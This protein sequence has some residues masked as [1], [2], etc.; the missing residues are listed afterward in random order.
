MTIHLTGLSGSEFA[1]LRQWIR[2][3][4]VIDL[5]HSPPVPPELAQIDRW[6]AFFNRPG[7]KNRLVTRYLYEHL[8]LAHLYFDGLDTGNYL[9]LVRSTTP[10]GETGP[11]HSHAASE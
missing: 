3:G 11:G 4:A 10:P 7:L 8:F 5:H 2:E 1:T 9:R 6:E